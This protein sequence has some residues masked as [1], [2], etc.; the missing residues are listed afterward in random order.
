MLTKKFWVF[1]FGT[2]VLAAWHSYS[3]DKKIKCGPR[4]N[5]LFQR[6]QEHG[7]WEESQGNDKLL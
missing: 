3:G 4:S 7:G 1:D 2:S 6:K 5:N